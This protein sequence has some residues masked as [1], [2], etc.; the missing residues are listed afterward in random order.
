MSAAYDP[1]NP[2]GAN[3][4]RG[5]RCLV[6]GAAGFIGTA[7]C[8]QLTNSGA[9]VWGLGRQSTA[10]AATDYWLTCDVTNQAQVSESMQECQPEVVFHLASIVSGVRKMESVLPMLHANLS[11]FVNVA[12]HAAD[13]KCDRIV[14]MG[15]LQEPDQALPATP[16]SPYAAA[17]F[18]ASCY[19]RMFAEVFNVPIVIARPLMVYGPG[20]LD[21]TKLVPHVIS[22][23]LSGGSA[24]LSSGTHR[25]DWVYVDDVCEALLAIASS[26][27]LIGQTID[28][29]TG[30]LTA[31]VDV[32]RG[33]A[34]RLHAA[35]SL[36]I[37]TLTDRTG[38]P[39][40]SADTATTKALTGWESRVELEDGLDLTIEWYK[41]N[42]ALGK[43]A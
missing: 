2:S 31:V 34:R 38:E 17:K 18:A 40:R 19:A 22:Q 8:R 33:L 3:V 27:E 11:G 9:E 21:R 39:T 1:T 43:G 30:K 36:M 23:L 29:G 5:K 7:L 25:F 10:A 26:K 15:S 13:V 32:A 37:G 35:D 20:Q 16:T 4:W 12:I 14:G 41:E 28:I 6:T 24:S 42:L